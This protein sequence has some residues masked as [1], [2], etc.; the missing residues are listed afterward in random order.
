MEKTQQPFV[1]GYKFR[2]YPNDQQKELFEKTFGCCRFVYNKLLAETKAEYQTY[3]QLRDE[4]NIINISKPSTSG[5]TLA[6]KAALIKKTI[7]I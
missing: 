3:V 2:I 4:G 1:K 5:F 7:R 6:T